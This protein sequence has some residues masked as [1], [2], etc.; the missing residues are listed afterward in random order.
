MSQNPNILVCAPNLLAIESSFHVGGGGGGG[1]YLYIHFIWDEKVKK[2]ILSTGW[3]IPI[4]FWCSALNYQ[5]EFLTLVLLLPIYFARGRNKISFQGLFC[6][7]SA[8]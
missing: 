8:I 7:G 4:L 5:S 3:A 2:K 1:I 6:L